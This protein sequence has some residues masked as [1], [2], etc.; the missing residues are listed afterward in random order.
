MCFNFSPTVILCLVLFQCHALLRL[1]ETCQ[2]AK[3]SFAEL[4]GSG[5]TKVSRKSKIRGR[6]CAGSLTIK[7]KVDGEY[8]RGETRVWSLFLS[9]QCAKYRMAPCWGGLKLKGNVFLLRFKNVNADKDAGNTMATR[10]NLHLLTHKKHI[11]A[12]LHV[13]L[14]LSMHTTVWV[15]EPILQMHV[16]FFVHMWAHVYVYLGDAPLI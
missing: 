15:M 10:Q 16:V 11:R 9:C 13:L 5:D 7:K 4:D 6:S 14:H 12:N 8:T 1:W 3:T 2:W